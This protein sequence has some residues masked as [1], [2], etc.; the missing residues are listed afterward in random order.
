MTSN[1]EL[2]YKPWDSNFFNREIYELV[3]LNQGRSLAADGINKMVESV[4][5]DERVLV[6]VSIDSGMFQVIPSLEDA[7]FRFVDSRIEFLTIE[8]KLEGKVSAPVGVFRDFIDSDW[9]QLNDLT[10]ES[11]AGNSN[12]MS[13]YNN[14]NYFSTEDSHRYYM[15]WHKLVLENT[16]P[17]FCVW[18]VSGE[19]CG[20]YTIVRKVFNGDDALP[21]YKVGLGAVKQ[22]YR[23]FGAQ[24]LMQQWLF[25]RAFDLKWVTVNSPALTNKA[26]I[27][28]N[29]R[30]RKIFDH[31]EVFMFANRQAMGI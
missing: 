26:G 7:G 5:A 13:R 6:Q 3:G 28:N 20:F 31:A 25:S 15:Q 9:D 8:E 19:I 1:L 21:H 11:F 23:S 17:M 24:N 10:F 12:F 27:K 14:R 29:I 30:A 16:H 18:D 2:T 22:G 4:L